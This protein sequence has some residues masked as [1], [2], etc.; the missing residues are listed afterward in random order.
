MKLKAFQKKYL[1][2][3]SHKMKP[4]VLIGKN[5]LSESVID[6]IKKSLEEQELIKIKVIDRDETDIKEAVRII[7]E[8]TE[9]EIIK[10]IGGTAVFYKENPENRKDYFKACGMFGQK[11]KLRK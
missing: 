1:K 9:S 7:L 3:L 11:S 10:V 8:Q 6:Q 2:A 4:I 5:G